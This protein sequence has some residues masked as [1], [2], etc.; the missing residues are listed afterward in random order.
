[1]FNIKPLPVS[2]Y[3]ST[4]DTDKMPSTKAMVSH[5]LTNLPAFHTRTAADQKKMISDMTAVL[6]ES[7]KHLIDATLD[8]VSDGIMGILETS[9]RWTPGEF[10][11]E[12]DLLLTAAMINIALEV[13]DRQWRNLAY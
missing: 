5:I 10:A 6:D 11:S 4:R 8:I 13:K 2:K 7:R 12:F 1:M 9:K 3:A